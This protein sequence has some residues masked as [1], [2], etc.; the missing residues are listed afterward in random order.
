M[1]SPCT[2]RTLPECSVTPLGHPLLYGVAGLGIRTGTCLS[3]D[4]AG[5][6]FS[7]SI[8]Y[9]SW[10]LRMPS[11]P[12]G[13][14]KTRR[15]LRG[16]PAPRSVL[17]PP[18]RPGHHLHVC[19]AALECAGHS[20]L[21]GAEPGMGAGP[22]LSYASSVL[23]SQESRFPRTRHGAVQV[24]MRPPASQPRIL[25]DARPA[26]S[27]EGGHVREAH[28][29]QVLYAVPF[30]SPARS[31]SLRLRRAQLGPGAQTWPTG[32]AV[33]TLILE[34]GQARVFYS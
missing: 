11:C 26:P 33:F 18:P 23:G 13:G 25:E 17:C 24:Q 32:F 29:G 12:P 28:R 21:V 27:P 6:L 15:A 7:V 4:R 34:E 5:S 30:P 20:L 22:R 14:G 9:V 16:A 31:L 3:G 19:R 10:L 2:L 8:R 1:K